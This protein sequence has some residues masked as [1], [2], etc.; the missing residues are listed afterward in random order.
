[1]AR[2]RDWLL[3]G[4]AVALGLAALGAGTYN[5]DRGLRLRAALGQDEAQLALAL[6]RYRAGDA[7]AAFA[8]FEPLMLADYAPAV[9]VVCDILGEPSLDDPRG[10][11]RQ[12]GCDTDAKVTPMTRLEQLSDVAFMAREW[13]AL[14]QVLARRLAAGD[15]RAHFDM[16]RYEALSRPEALQV[17]AVVAHLRRAA[18][19]GDP[20][21]QYLM[22]VYQLHDATKDPAA[23]APLSQT[24]AKLIA[25]SPP[26]TAGDA[27]F[28]LAKLMQAGL[29]GSELAYSDVLLRA[30]ELG[31]RFAAG[32]LAQYLLSNP[33][34]GEI[35]GADAAAWVEKA[36]AHGDPVA[37][38][39]HALAL[40]DAAPAD[41]ASRAD[42]NTD[43]A[44]KLLL[45]SAATGFAPSHTRLG[46]LYWQ[47][48]QRAGGD[49][50][51]GRQRALEH[52]QIAADK[53]DAN[54]L[55]NLA[56]VAL[57]Q[58]RREAALEYLEASAAQGHKAAGDALKAAR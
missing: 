58:G 49:V 35:G 9:A 38:Y 22:A 26:V 54:A 3:G 39:N 23:Q 51:A 36:A 46:A 31:N 30:D 7:T 21:G 25:Q 4:A 18:D 2:T 14:E 50:E 53:G 41:A 47:Q 12:D 20:R 5:T 48:P 43:A 11:A 55:Y 13:G 8:L 10:A 28:E 33:D 19:H 44:E 34:K 52:W 45:A 56:Q 6:R 1:M 16:A 17:E 42:A 24:F 37:Q 29:I 57:A 40:L 27:Y 15:T 32:Y